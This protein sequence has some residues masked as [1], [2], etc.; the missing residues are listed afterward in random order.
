MRSTD[1]QPPMFSKKIYIL[2]NLFT[3]ANMFCGFFAIVTSIHGKYVQ[4]CW[5]LMAGM[6]FD[7]M[8]GRV[9]RF[10]RSTS[11]FGLQYDS[12]SDLVSFGVAP[13][14]VIYLWALQPFG[15]LGWLVGFLYM[16]CAALRL[17]RFN[18]MVAN[19]P[20]GFFQGIPSPLAACSLASG[21]LFYRELSL[22]SY[23]IPK[24]V[25]IL[26]VA[27]SVASLMIS[28]ISFPSFKEFKISREN[29]VQSLAA[30]VLVMVLIAI[31]PEVT[32]FAMTVF[33]ISGGLVMEFYRLLSRKKPLLE[34]KGIH[35]RPDES[36]FN[37]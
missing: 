3:T 35:A 26:P 33:Y 10:T 25:F 37:G 28:S 11:D 17:A 27:L 31:R 23:G 19:V 2:P 4:S 1:S 5:M 20:K 22:E 24:H 15:R 32:L 13:G 12:L 14:L 8:D 21:I 29:S 34:T 36:T 30:I 9:A 6:L 7:S 16:V 18:V